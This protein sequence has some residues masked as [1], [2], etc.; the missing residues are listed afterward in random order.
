MDRDCRV[1]AFPKLRVADAELEVD[2]HRVVEEA[3]VVELGEAAGVER[4][5]EGTEGEGVETVEVCDGRQRE[6][7]LRQGLEDG[8]GKTH[9]DRVV[10]SHQRPSAKRFGTA[11]RRE[12][13]GRAV[14]ARNR[15]ACLFAMKKVEETGNKGIVSASCS[16][17]R[18]K[19]TNSRSASIFPFSPTTLGRPSAV[20]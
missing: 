1:F 19:S 3:V 8:G 14:K 17:R 13:E 11:R 2:H 15:C 10:A 16:K 6:N 9:C 20:K 5:E 12:H 4:G 7:Q 18:S